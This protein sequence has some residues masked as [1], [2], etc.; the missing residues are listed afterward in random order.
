M[1]LLQCPH[2]YISGGDSVWKHIDTDGDLDTFEDWSRHVHGSSRPT[3]ERDV[4]I[5]RRTRTPIA[6]SRQA[7]SSDTR[8][9]QPVWS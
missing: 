2:G 7:G 8:A 9:T 5:V 4:E 3:F 6:M 1:R